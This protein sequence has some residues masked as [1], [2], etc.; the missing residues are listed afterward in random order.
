[1]EVK[2]KINDIDYNLYCTYS[3]EIIDIGEKYAEIER[4]YEGEILLLPYKL[5]YVPEDV[6]DEEPYI[7]E[8][9]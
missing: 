9:E 5:E 3:K 1:M 4:N 8:D 2:F 6:E 7:C